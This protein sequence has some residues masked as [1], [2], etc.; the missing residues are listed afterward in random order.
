VFDGAFDVW[1]NKQLLSK[2]SSTYGSPELAKEVQI[3]HTQTHKQRD[4]TSVMNE[5]AADHNEQ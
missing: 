2:S 1:D 3:Q 4:E 5:S